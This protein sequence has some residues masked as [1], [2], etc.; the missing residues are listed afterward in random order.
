MRGLDFD[1]LLGIDRQAGS[2]VV[3]LLGPRLSPGRP[4]GTVLG[5]D[6]GRGRLQLGCYCRG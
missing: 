3:L 4:N 5:K 2:L 1:D 6:F